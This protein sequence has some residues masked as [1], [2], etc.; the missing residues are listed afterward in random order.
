MSW[1]NITL[2]DKEFYT[3]MARYADVTNLSTVEKYYK[4][5]VETVIREMIINHTCRLPLLGTFNVR[6]INESFQIQRGKDGKE[7]MY[8]VPA[9]IVPTFIPH[10]DFINDINMIAVTKKGRRRVRNGDLT[11]RDYL[12]QVRSESMGMVGCLSEERIEMSRKKFKE[13]LQDKKNKI[14]GKVDKTENE[15]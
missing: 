14:K 1:G 6:E 15:D 7:K 8:K 5:M 10:D 4:A 12:R 3:L 2:S 11:E 9:R 13:L